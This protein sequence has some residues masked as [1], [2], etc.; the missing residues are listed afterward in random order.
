MKGAT[1]RANSVERKNSGERASEKNG[2]N[3][4]RAKQIS[5]RDEKASKARSSAK[6]L[7]A[8][9]SERPSEKNGGNANRARQISQRDQKASKARS[10]AKK[11]AAAKSGER[12]SERNGG[13]ANKA[14][15]ITQRD[16]KA[17]KAQSA[18]LAAAKSLSSNKAKSSANKRMLATAA[19]TKQT[20]GAVSRPSAS[21]NPRKV[22]AVKPGSKPRITTARPEKLAYRKGAGNIPH[23]G[24][25][26]AARAGIIDPGGYIRT[27]QGSGRI[28]R[29]HMQQQLASLPNYHNNFS[30]NNGHRISNHSQWPSHWNP[31]SGGASLG[32][33]PGYSWNG[34]NY[35]FS[36]YAPSGYCPTPYLF[37][38][39]CGAFCQPGVGYADCLPYG[40]NQPISIAINEVVPAYDANG[41]IIGYQ[42]E[43]FYYDACWDAN[44]QA[45]GYYDY[46]GEFHWVT[47]PWLN[48]WE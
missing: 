32:Y 21:A 47:F 3:A 44:A 27:A 20:R 5:Q 4:N 14:R 26:G 45:Y 30:N 9:K 12:P 13:N 33:Y 25:V 31:G 2:G 36:Y 43:T 46:R 35:P 1:A 37:L 10:S 22:S 24:R 23:A 6:K 40:Y 8:A 34:T 48:T 15:Q 19:G 29:S 38:S 39:D 42:D 16:E 11:L 17:S 41:N 7:A 18:K 28:D